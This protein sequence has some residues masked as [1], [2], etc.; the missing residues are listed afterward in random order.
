MAV[1]ASVN[2][3]VDIVST[4]DGI[5]FR[6]TTDASGDRFTLNN[7]GIGQATTP[8]ALNVTGNSSFVGVTTFTGNV[9]VANKLSFGDSDSSTT[10]LATFGAGDDLS[11]IHI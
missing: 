10:N 4:G 8:N 6:S 3:I 1:G 7:L 5:S 11:L 2:D 9:S